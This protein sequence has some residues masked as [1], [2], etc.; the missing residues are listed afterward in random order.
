[1]GN[2]CPKCHSDNSDTASFCA[3]CGTSL[4]SNDVAQSSFTKTMETPREELTTGSTFTNRYQIIEELGKGGMGHVY[5]VLDKE[6]NEK[7]A[8]KLCFVSAKFGQRLNF[9]KLR[10]EIRKRC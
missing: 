7:I 8:L 4:S 2:K 5:K 6:T 10:F 1:M 3:D 9:P